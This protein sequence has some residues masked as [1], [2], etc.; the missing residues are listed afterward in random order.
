MK[1]PFLPQRASGKAESDD[2]FLGAY[3][4]ATDAEKVII[5][6]LFRAVP[7]VFIIQRAIQDYLSDFKI[8]DLLTA[9][10]AR[11]RV[12]W[13]NRLLENQGK[14]DWSTASEKEARFQEY[15]NELREHLRIKVRLSISMI[16]KILDNI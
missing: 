16:A 13:Q 4:P 2:Q 12:E 6:S 7:K 5:L 8:E 10:S 1:N 14:K 11:A 9:L 3:I 15:K